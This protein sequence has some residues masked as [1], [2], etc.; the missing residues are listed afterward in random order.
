MSILKP[1]IHN[2]TANNDSNVVSIFS[3]QTPQH[4][5]NKKFVH[6][7]PEFDGLCILYSNK[8]CIGDKLYTM[9]ILCW[10]IQACGEVVAIV[11]WMNKAIP[12]TDLADEEHGFFEGYYDTKSQDI[13]YN[14]PAHKV[15]ELE[16]LQT[17]SSANKG[18]GKDCIQEIPDSI[19]THAMI[20]TAEK[21][22]MELTEVLSWRLLSNGDIEAMLVDEELVDVTP[23]LL[24]DPCLY[25]VS[26]NTNF[27]YFFQHHI[28]NLIKAEDPSTLSAI[29]VLLD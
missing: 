29:S 10:G 11:A 8:H 20:Y 2:N 12:C 16:A 14:P 1:S 18:D 15:V 25:P 27:R 13:F 5:L 23:V 21:N 4:L 9:K 22:V 28:A 24:G 17:Y 6:L 3:K 19:G 26:E 7:S